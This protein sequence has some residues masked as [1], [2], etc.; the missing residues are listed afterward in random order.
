[1]E[2]KLRATTIGRS[3]LNFSNN[4]QNMGCLLYLFS[5]G[6]GLYGFVRNVVDIT[7]T[8]VGVYIRPPYYRGCRE[9]GEA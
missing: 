7:T 4:K 1:M 8:F 5:N 2:V 6:H 9:G 3:S